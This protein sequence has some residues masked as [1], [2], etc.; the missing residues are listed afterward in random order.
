MRQDRKLPDPPA[1][2]APLTAEEKAVVEEKKALREKMKA[3]RDAI[4]EETRKEEDRILTDTILQ[5]PFYAQAKWI[6]TYVSFGSEVDTHA[7]IRSAL[8][9]RKRVFVPCVKDKAMDFYEIEALTDLAPGT[10]GIPEPEANPAKKFPYSLHLSLDRA[11]E[12][13]VFVPGLAFD[14]NCHRIGYGGGYYDRFLASFRKKMAVGLCYNEQVQE[15]IPCLPEDMQT[16]IV[17]TPT[18]AFF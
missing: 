5:T 8:K 15:A 13:A 2:R 11:E 14:R 18:G 16:D 3:I 4:P 10:M 7:L 1:Q 17:V 6:L 9:D 12:C